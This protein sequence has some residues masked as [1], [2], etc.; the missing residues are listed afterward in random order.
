MLIE[1]LDFEQAYF[2]R[3]LDLA[4]NPQVYATLFENIG[5]KIAN[6]AGTKLLNWVGPT[7]IDILGDKIAFPRLEAPNADLIKKLYS[8]SLAPEERLV[9]LPTRGLF[10]ETKLGH[11][12]VAEEIDETSYWKWEEHLLPVIA[13]EIVPIEV[14]RPEINPPKTDLQATLHDL[15]EG[16]VKTAQAASKVC[17]LKHFSS[18]IQV[19]AGFGYSE[20]AADS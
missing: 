7:P 1:H 12:N 10:A 18:L 15:I 17:H 4:T 13:P 5:V 2:K 20:E 3:V 8:T 16:A 6:K 19:L 11:C 9:S 14:V